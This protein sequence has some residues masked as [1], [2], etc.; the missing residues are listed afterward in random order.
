[1]S[2][3][4]DYSDDLMADILGFLGE[5]TGA[6]APTVYTDADP[7]LLLEKTVAGA[8]QKLALPWVVVN[9]PEVAEEIAALTGEKTA[10]TYTFDVW[11]ACGY[12]D[13]EVPRLVQRQKARVVYNKLMDKRNSGHWT[14]A[15]DWAYVKRRRYDNE[16]NLA[17]EGSDARV[18]VTHMTYEVQ[19]EPVTIPLQD[20]A[21][22]ATLD[23]YCDRT[24]PGT[25]Y[26]AANLKVSAD[27]TGRKQVAV[28]KFSLTSLP[29]FD[30]TY[31]RA[32]SVRDATLT[33]TAAAS[34]AGSLLAG[35]LSNDPG[36]EG[37]ITWTSLN[38][39]VAAAT[40]PTVVAEAPGGTVDI[41]VTTILRN[42]HQ[43]GNANYGFLLYSETDGDAMEF[44]SREDAGGP[45]LAVTTQW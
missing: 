31:K 20:W 23:T 21:L 1:M 38:Q 16:I 25:N 42:W 28:V 7:G 12:G 37:T 39:A 22:A 4:Y 45:L 15:L 17:F 26:A 29:T 27:A 19:F 18:R 10:Q 44:Y 2:T 24:V 13:G 36:A 41:D 8:D 11:H 33:L 32:G 30:M 9:L 6:N 14:H 40:S 43:T 34:S 3:Q 35:Q 5:I